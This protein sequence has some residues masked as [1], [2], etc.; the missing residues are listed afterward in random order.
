MTIKGQ[1]KSLKKRLKILNIKID[2]TSGIDK[3]FLLS[4]KQTIINQINKLNNLP[5]QSYL[6]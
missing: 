5:I 1:L 2:I 6:K 3:V 4:D